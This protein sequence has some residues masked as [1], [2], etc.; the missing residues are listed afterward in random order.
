MFMEFAAMAPSGM[1]DK[2]IDYANPGIDLH[3]S[4]LSESLDYDLTMVRLVNE[5]GINSQHAGDLEAS[6]GHRPLQYKYV[7]RYLECCKNP[8][9]H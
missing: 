2:M 3:L 7:C 6:F 1:M 4:M 5:L 8:A 9:L